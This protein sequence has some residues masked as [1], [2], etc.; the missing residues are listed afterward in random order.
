MTERPGDV[1][2]AGPAGLEHAGRLPDR[3][4]DGGARVGVIDGLSRQQEP[5]GYPGV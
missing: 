3:G 5:R 2:R 1:V 4:A